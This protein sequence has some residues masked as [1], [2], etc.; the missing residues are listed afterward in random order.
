[1]TIKE[2]QQQLSKYEEE[3]GPETE[4]HVH[5]YDRVE[6]ETRAVKASNFYLSCIDSKF[7]Y[8]VLE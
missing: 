2:L 3:L 7:D 8:L 6:D 5:E 4:I 1:M